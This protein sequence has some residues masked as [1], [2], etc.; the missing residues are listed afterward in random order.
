MYN[1]LYIDL[2]NFR[3]VYRV[4]NFHYVYRD[5]RIIWPSLYILFKAL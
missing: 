4:T 2:T 3:Y 1:F 5:I